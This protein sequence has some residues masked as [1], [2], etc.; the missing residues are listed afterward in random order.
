MDF[1]STIGDIESLLTD[2]RRVRAGVVG[3]LCLDV[4]WDVDESLSEASIETGLPTLPVV[5]ARCAPGGAA[6]VARNLA[7][8]GCPGV[9]AFG[10][11]GNDV[12]GRELRHWLHDAR[13]DTTGVLDGPAG[14]AT[15][16]YVKPLIEGSEAR[17]YDLGVANVCDE[18]T[19]ARLLLAVEAAAPDLDVLVINQQ[20]RAGIHTETFV[21]KLNR[22]IARRHDLMFVAD[23]RDSRLFYLGAVQR[24]SCGILMDAYRV[25]EALARLTEL[26]AFVTC[27]DAGC[28]IAEANGLAVVPAIEVPGPIDPVGA[29]D[30]FTASVAVAMAAGR[31]SRAAAEFATLAAAVTVGKVGETGVASPDEILELAARAL[32]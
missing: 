6:N 28:F 18:T 2:L 5:G 7:A 14:W 21:R 20:V 31:T 12:F 24:R 3:D 25:V 22:V 9:R 16:A 32:S 30:T 26:P 19:T 15:H 11:V 29:G 13:V 10:V 23:V 27:G 8:L 4:Y 1:E 17:R